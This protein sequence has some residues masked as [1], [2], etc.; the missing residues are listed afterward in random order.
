MAKDSVDTF[1]K[2]VPKTKPLLL[3]MSGHSS[4]ADLQVE[5]G[6]TPKIP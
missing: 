1:Q 6:L 2:L 3:L 5:V 4:E